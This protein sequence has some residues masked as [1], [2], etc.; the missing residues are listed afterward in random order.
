MIGVTDMHYM[1]SM[2]QSSEYLRM[3]LS[4]MG[5]FG[6]PVDPLNYSV[7]YEYV[8]GKNEKLSIIIDEAL[9]QSGDI[10]PEMNM[11]LYEKYVAPD[12]KMLVDK[13]REELRAV[14]GKI[15]E[16]VSDAGGQLSSF[17]EVCEKYAQALREDLD[18][19][20]VTRVVEDIISEAKVMI[21]SVGVLKERLQKST[22]EV[23]KLSRNLEIIKE[24]AS[25]DLL[26]G[27]RNRFHLATV[28]PEHARSADETG[29]E[30]CLIF[31]DIDHFKR[32]ND[33]HGHL[34]GDKV[35]RI[36]AEVLKQCVKGRD[37]VIRYGGEEFVI[38]LPDTPLQGAVILA[39]KICAHFRNLNWK[40][41]D[42]GRFIGPVHISCGV[43]RYRRGEGL[44]T[45]LLR[46]DKAL[47]RSK[48][49]GRCRVTS[50]AELESS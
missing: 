33:N 10:T 22:R 20:A 17:G 3:A 1:D 46:A 29:S 39:D 47:Y 44:E 15:L 18:I 26:T 25:T 31:V 43:S 21:S 16:H 6:I 41:I 9:E 7:W 37:L 12:Q 5:R 49:N 35:L 40:I 32:I 4:H 48:V 34:V 13:I 27:I 42:N 36:T 50:E 19:E 28:F 8:S 11:N 23:E 45:F 14:L 38:L 2:E 30:L 24:Q